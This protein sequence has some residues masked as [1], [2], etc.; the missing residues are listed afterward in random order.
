M[1]YRAVVFDLDGTL[2]NTLRDIAAAMNRS[3][4]MHGLPEHPVDAYRYLVG[5][6]A[7][8][9]A[10]R[11]VGERLDMQ[12]AVLRD[13]QA[14]YEQHT[15][16][17]T[18]PYD[19]I[20]EL[21]AGLTQRGMMLCV[22]SNKPH[23]DTLNVVRYFFPQTPFRVIRGQMEGVPVK[24]DPAGALAIAEEIGAQPRE[25]LYLGDT[26]VDMETATRAGMTPVGV[27][28]GFRDEKELRESGARLLLRHPTELLAE[29]DRGL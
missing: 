6:G 12:V 21:L 13:Y 23:A 7:K 17:T 22:L 27:L 11:A 5:N 18:K 25:C 20:P 3:L 1:K 19:G 8:K 9:L 14:H 4:R 16:D 15:R 24:P 10:E 26:S 29:L 28:W 2:T